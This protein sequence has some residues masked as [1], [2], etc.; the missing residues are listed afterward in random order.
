MY[1]KK[2]EE[3]INIHVSPLLSFLIYNIFY[4]VAHAYIDWLRY[5]L[6][7]IFRLLCY[8]LIVIEVNR[9]YVHLAH[10]SAGI[11]HKCKLFCGFHAWAQVEYR[12]FILYLFGQL[13]T[14]KEYKG[15]F[16]YCLSYSG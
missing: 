3:K 14:F 2:M 13:E 12:F 16:A 5:M 11:N 9:C 4:S 8:T 6:Y 15:K 10:S 7:M 1:L